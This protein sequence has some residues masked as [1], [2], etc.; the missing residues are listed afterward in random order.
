MAGRLQSREGMVDRPDGGKQLVS[1]QS[2]NME[3]ER[4]QEGDTS[5]QATPQ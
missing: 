1:W 3:R 2:G 5:F 4:C